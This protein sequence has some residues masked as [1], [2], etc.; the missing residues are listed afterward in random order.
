MNTFNSNMFG[1][2]NS[3]YGS[4][5][6]DVTN[7]KDN[8]WYPQVPISSPIQPTNPL[9]S[10]N[11]FN[12]QPDINFGFNPYSPGEYNNTFGYTSGYTSSYTSGY[13]YGYRYGYD[14]GF[15]SGYQKA[16]MTLIKILI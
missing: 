3:P 1:A 16:I 11:G 9:N 13:T 8:P 2:F 10:F 4:K 15:N 14:N 6:P 7:K 5:N 12:K